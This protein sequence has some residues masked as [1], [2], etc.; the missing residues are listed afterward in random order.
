MFRDKWLLAC[1]AAC[2]LGGGLLYTKTRP[3]DLHAAQL[4]YARLE[5]ANLAQVNLA[6]ADL[7]QAN[8]TR[9][10]LQR[11]GLQS[12]DLRRTLLAGSDL[13]D[14]DM[15]GARLQGADFSCAQL[16]NADLREALY[17]N[18]TVWPDGFDPRESGAVLTMDTSANSRPA[19]WPAEGS[20]WKTEFG[21]GTP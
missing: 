8:L 17:D 2:I 19:P 14:A 13:R 10:C 1:M 9:A 6:G 15:R 12:A 18:T 7:R 21:M 5:G 20:W 3:P 16:Y 4:C 11:A